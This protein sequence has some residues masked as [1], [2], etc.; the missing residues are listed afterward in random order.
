[1]QQMIHLMPDGLV[2][3]LFIPQLQFHRLWGTKTAIRSS[4]S[5]PH[6]PRLSSLLL[7]SPRGL[8]IPKTFQLR[9]QPV[10]MITGWLFS[11]TIVIL[12]IVYFNKKNP[13]VFVTCELFLCV[14]VPVWTDV[15][16]GSSVLKAHMLV[17]SFALPW[18]QGLVEIEPGLAF[19]EMI[20]WFPKPLIS[21][22]TL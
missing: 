20:F 1:M 13:S 19:V 7:A 11:R 22:V 5:S 8:Q 16:W 2:R 10:R 15:S 9:Y 17:P 18:W 4:C 14:F 21:L 12:T 3:N 6:Q